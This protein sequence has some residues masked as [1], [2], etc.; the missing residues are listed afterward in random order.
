MTRNLRVWFIVATNKRNLNSSTHPTKARSKFKTIN[1]APNSTARFEFKVI[2]KALLENFTNSKQRYHSKT[3]KLVE[4]IALL[5]AICRQLPQAYISRLADD[6]PPLYDDGSKGNRPLQER[7]PTIPTS[8]YF[9]AC[10]YDFADSASLEFIQGL[11]TN[12]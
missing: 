12:G 6:L 2:K 10:G 7:L 3:F 5:Q 8:L 1:K 11:Q 9:K 4:Q